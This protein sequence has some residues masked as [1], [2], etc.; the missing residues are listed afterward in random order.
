MR[1]AGAW[2]L[3]GAAVSLALALALFDP[4]LFTGGDNAAYYALAEALARGRGYV[5]LTAPGAPVESQYPPGYPVFLVPFWLAFSGSY[6]GV[7]AASWVAAA[8]ALWGTWA[9]ARSHRDVPGWV[10]AAAVALVGLYPVFLE[11][12][13]WVLSEMTYLAVSLAALWA[14][15]RA[16][17]APAEG[18]VEDRWAGWWLAG[19]VLSVAAFYV[20]TAGIALPAAALLWAL[21][22][23]GWRRAAAAGTALLVGTAPWLLWTA[24][25]PPPTGGYLEQL[26]SS[27]PYDPAGPAVSIGGMAARVGANARAYA[28]DELPRLVW[29]ELLPAPAAA[30]AVLAFGALLVYGAARAIR[31]RGI[32]V[33]ELTLA[34]TVLLILSWPWVQDRFF[35]TIAPLLWIWVL[36]GLSGA[37]RILV[38]R[39]WPGAALAG[40][41]ALALLIGAAR[42][43]PDQWAVTRAHMEGD[44]LAGYEPIWRDY[45]EAARWIGETAPDAV[46]VARKPTLAWYW[47]RRPCVVY[48]FRYDP[49]A[50]WRFIRAS[51]AT[52]VLLDGLGSTEAYLV[53][54]LEEHLDEVR[55][56]HAA[57]GRNAFVLRIEPAR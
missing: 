23:R 55:A 30:V 36:G 5:D 28:L 29:P 35:L 39:T 54:A 1:R 41:V 14:F 51:G 15:A 16:A 47:S 34:L 22:A 45:F 37:A 25:N 26:L 32:Q 46:I 20:R 2:A 13:H 19:L 24:Q 44:E 21:L 12:A 53:P 9:L 38:D 48:P 42:K 3:A 50:T 11:Y 43:V 6:V 10:G 33:W 8:A 7:K 49:P 57:P 40:L 4:R 56:V 27:N 17:Q 18:Q 31:L 52:H